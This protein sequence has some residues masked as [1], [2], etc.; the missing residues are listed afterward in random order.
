MILKCNT[1]LKTQEILI[2][3]Q[4]ENER[5][6]ESWGIKRQVWLNNLMF[7]L[8]PEACIFILQEK[9]F[10][11]KCLR[12][13]LIFFFNFMHDKKMCSSVFVCENIYVMSIMC[14]KCLHEYSLQEIQLSVI[15]STK[16]IYIAKKRLISIIFCLIQYNI[17]P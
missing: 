10:Q 4:N 11:K 6:E 14:L 1:V 8:A 3:F 15:F 7:L 2:W 17:L 12:I 9:R 13:E 5:A 16:I